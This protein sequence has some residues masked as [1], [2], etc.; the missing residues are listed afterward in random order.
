MKI[1][2]SAHQLQRGSYDKA[3]ASKFNFNYNSQPQKYIKLMVD[4]AGR[5]IMRDSVK[6]V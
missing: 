5:R 3:T 4:D 1:Y 2:D 6:I